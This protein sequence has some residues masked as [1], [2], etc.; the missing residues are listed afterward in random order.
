MNDL[1][2][3]ELKLNSTKEVDKKIRLACELFQRGEIDVDQ[4]SLILSIPSGEVK[5]AFTKAGLITEKTILIT[6]G[7]GFIGA[8]FVHYMLQAHPHYRVI[9]YDKLTYAG[10]PDNLRG[11]GEKYANYTFIEGDIADEVNID[12][13]MRLHRPDYIINFAAETHVDRSIHVNARDFVMTNVVGVHVLLEAARKYK[14]DRYINFSTDEVFGSVD[15]E[16]TRAFKEHDAFDPSSPYS[17]TKAG[18]D[19]LCRAYSMSMEVPVIVT[20]CSNNFGKFQYPEKL[21]PFF[22]YKA[23]RNEKLPLYGDGRHVRDWLHV[24]DNCKA[25]DEILHRGTIGEVYN[26]AASNERPNIEVAEGILKVLGRPKSLLT[27]VDDRPGH[28]RRYSIDTS[29]ISNE[30]QWKPTAQKKF[31]SQLEETI[32]WYLDNQDWAAGVEKRAKL[33]NSH[34]SV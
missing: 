20:H 6:G 23:L 32:E 10:N 22:V 27:Y 31:A 11:L 25:V 30:L 34:I 33:F 9:N 8:N 21:I 29:K 13:V 1:V 4:A 24:W 26:I 18:G 19:L 15:L 28:D 12:R 3:K 16:E 7:A 5:Q 2:R 17:A 14:V